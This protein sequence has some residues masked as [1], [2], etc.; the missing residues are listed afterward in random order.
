MLT[1]LY[2]PQA[3]L[4]V[5]LKM[6]T[7]APEGSNWMQVIREGAEEVKEKTKGRVK[8]KFYPGGVMGNYL[9]V[10]KKIRIGQLHGGAFVAGDLAH[11]YP[12][13]QIYSLPFLFDSY[14]DV[15]YVR[16]R[17]DQTI[18]DGLEQHGFVA[19]G[20]SE[21]GFVYP[22]SDKPVRGPADLSGRK[23]WLP[24]GDVFGETIFKAAGIAPVS[25]PI[26]DVYTGLQTGLIDSLGSTP[27]GA[28][29]FQ[30]HTRMKYLTDSA[31]M[32][33]LALFV[34]DKNSFAG[35]TPADQQ[36]VRDVIGEKFSLLD[37]INRRDNEQAKAAL[38]KQGIEI[39]ELSDD[40][41]GAWKDVAEKSIA[42]L[43]A[44]GAFTEQ[45]YETVRSYLDAAAQ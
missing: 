3:T 9:S 30:W 12:D 42:R 41:L 4:A 40:E 15:D 26:S 37:E 32:Y 29:A 38:V 7:I 13:V 18:I 5:T 19:A 8:F 24:E 1:A 43:R 28:I 31:M 33:L 14:E 44:R 39:I 35:L 6:A 11:I 45:A 20:I 16:S 22:M 17:M 21:G 23:V 27:A 10:L 36:V 25:L 34:V 2:G